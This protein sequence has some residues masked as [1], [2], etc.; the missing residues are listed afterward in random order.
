MKVIKV[1]TSQ[2][3]LGKNIGSEKAPDK[4]LECLKNIS[5]K[6]DGKSLV[7]EVGSIPINSSNIEET[8]LNIENSEGDLFIGGDHSITYSLFKSL[9]KKYK[10]AGLVMFDAHPDCEN[11]FSPPSHEDFIQVLIEQGILKKENLILIGLRNIDKKEYYYLKDNNIKYYTVKQLTENI[12]EAS[13]VIMETSRKFEALYVSIDIDVVDPSQAPGTGY[14]EPSGL[15]VRELIYLVNRLK[16][17]KN[18]KR[19]DL[20]EVNPDKDVN[21]ITSK[22]AA[23]IISEL[24]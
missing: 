8:N 22:L 16:M 2:G 18:L 6:D 21:N 24:L 23:R 3:S 7:Y 15:Y 5:I 19:V 14:P 4:I 12:E 1:P 13:D 20:V 11:N 10:N 9:S 17:L